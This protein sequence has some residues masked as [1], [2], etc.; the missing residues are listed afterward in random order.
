MKQL[1]LSVTPRQ[2]TGR[3]ISQRLRKSGQ[4]P[5][6][7]YGKSGSRALCINES[8]L[9]QLMRATS[10]SAALL[11]I[12]ESGRSAALSIV[13]D[14]QRH[15]ITDRFMHVDLLELDPNEEVRM[16]IPVHIIG[17]SFGV[18]NENGVLDMTRH[19]VEVRCLPKNL[20]SHITI[21]I[22]DL[23]VGQSVHVAQLP[24]LAGVTYTDNADLAI[25]ACASPT[26]EEE[27]TA[28]AAVAETDAAAE[29]ADKETAPDAKEAKK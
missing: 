10:G 20:P 2:G 1:T 3:G 4:I 7:I 19:S 26:V 9:R 29:G 5:A 8:E 11:E 28:A 14:I 13:K 23:R 21:D 25:V 22:T 17:E 12:N 16:Q 6:V 18:K 27:P 15:S 24:Q